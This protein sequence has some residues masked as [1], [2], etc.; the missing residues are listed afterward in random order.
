MVPLFC[1][2]MFHIF[3]Q[4]HL[5]VYCLSFGL[6]MFSYFN[7]LT[8]DHSSLGNHLEICT[9]NDLIDSFMYTLWPHFSAT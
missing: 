7:M 9:L 4:L 5:S 1:D 3:L 2:Q 8:C 6:N